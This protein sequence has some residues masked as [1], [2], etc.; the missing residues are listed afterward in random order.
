MYALGSAEDVRAVAF[1]RLKRGEEMG[2]CGLAME[3]GLL[4]KVGV[5]Q[6][7]GSAGAKEYA[8]WTEMI[9]GW[10]AKIGM[11]GTEFAHG[12]AR[13]DP[14]RGAC[15]QCDQHA[16]CRIAEKRELADE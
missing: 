8:S 1:A 4:P 16:F 5:V 9:A 15:E 13:V 14:K 10:R 6:D 7:N 2:F 3:K 12:E 11:L